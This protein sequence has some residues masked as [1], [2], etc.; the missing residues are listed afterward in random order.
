MSVSIVVIEFMQ[1]DLAKYALDHSLQ[2]IDAK[3]VI[4]ISDRDFIPGSTFV[5][6][7]QVTDYKEYN[8][9]M[10]TGMA[11]HV[12]T[13]HMLVVQT[14][15]I[16]NDRTKWT[17][18]FLKYDYIGAPWPWKAEG[19][20]IG[21]GG[22]SL[23]SKRMLDA[24]LDEHIKLKD[25]EDT[26]IAE[27]RKYLEETYNVKFA[28]TSLA[29]QFSFELGVYEGS[30][31]FH[32]MWNVFNLMS[33]S[34]M[35]YYV[36]QMNYKGWNIYRWHHTL[37]AVMR[38]GRMDIYEHMVGVLSTTAP[39]LLTDLAKWVEADGNLVGSPIVIN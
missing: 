12:N 17:D 36:T 8:Q 30:F 25:L 1:H 33:D 20:N 39:D 34:D 19:D 16:A 2:H 32:G 3:E 21:N 24:C 4:V 13:D 26:A 29:K 23:R 14:D 7:N 27:N 11:E 28:P 38:R 10:L 35:D 5:Q 15:G 9:L 22:F 31:G 18:E 37:A 6:H